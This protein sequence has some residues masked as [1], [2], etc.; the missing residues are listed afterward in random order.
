MNKKELKKQVD[1]HVNA[2]TLFLK[3]FGLL[4][5]VAVIIKLLGG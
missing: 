5:L 4:T 1:D 2:F 3:W